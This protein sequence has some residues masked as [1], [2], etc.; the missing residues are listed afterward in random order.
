[1][2][3]AFLKRTASAYLHG[4]HKPFIVCIE[5]LAPSTVGLICHRQDPYI[6]V[7]YSYSSVLSDAS[8]L[9]GQGRRT[10]RGVYW[11]EI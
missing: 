7:T 4:Y 6:L 10:H 2:V 8:N 11:N 3:K 9:E 5:T 1:M